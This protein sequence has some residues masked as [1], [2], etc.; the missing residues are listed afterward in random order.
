[1]ADKGHKDSTTEPEEQTGKR[2]ARCAG[3]KSPLEEHHWGIPSKFCQ[4]YE[5]CSPK[6]EGKAEGATYAEID[7]CEELAEELN[8]LDLE[9]RALR[10]RDEEETLRLRI[11]EKRKAIEELR[12]SI[13]RRRDEASRPW[14]SNDLRKVDLE[15]DEVTRPRR[16]E[17]TRPLTTSALRKMELESGQDKTPL[18][19][20]LSV[21]NPLQQEQQLPFTWLQQDAPAVASSYTRL[22][23][24]SNGKQTDIERQM[25]FKWASVNV[26]FPVEGH[27]FSTA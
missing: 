20:L 19:D 23:G 1:M 4:G 24:R 15:D 7:V 5:K 21:L 10:R 6:K 27:I 8:A 2:V 11:A 26:R 9:E 16:D 25:P 13:S 3:C 12:Q 14:T 18:D 22:A 17:V